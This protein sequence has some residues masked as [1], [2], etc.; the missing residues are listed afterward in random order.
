MVE[1]GK[2]EAILTLDKSKFD[3]GLSQAEGQFTGL[4]SKAA[5]AG[6][7][8]AGAM[9]TAG[10]AA[11]VAV[12][13]IA[14][15]G[16]SA[17]LNVEKAAS[18]AA[19]KA[20]D[21]NG[22]SADQIKAQ[23][24]SIQDHV[25]DISNQLAATTIFDPT[26][27][28]NAFDILAAK[29]ADIANIGQ[30]ELL[31]F[32]DLAAGTQ[33]DLATATDLVTGAINSFGLQMSDSGMVADQMAMAMNGSS[34]A[35][36]TLNYAL[37]QGGATAAA[38]GMQL[39]EF[40]AIVGVLAD[41][42]YTGEQSGA[43][44]KTA[45]LALYTPTQKQTDALA[46]LGLTYD[47]VDPRTHK[48][49]DTLEL[50]LSKGA[51]I[52]DF[53]NIFTDSSGAIMYA[54]AGAGDACDDL[55]A[56]IDG[57]SGLAHAQAS[58]IMDTDK[59]VGA[60]ET[61]KGATEGMTAAI[62]GAL[63]PAA[64]KLL[65]TW[66]AIAPAVQEFAVALASGDWAKAGEM[67]VEAF[68]D[69]WEAIQEIDWGAIATKAVSVIQ[70]GWQGLSNLGSQLLSWLQGVNWSGIAETIVSVVRT[71]WDA[72]QDLGQ[73]LYDWILSVDWAG[74]ATSIATT[75]KDTW[76]TITD[77]AGPIIDKFVEDFTEW[78]DSGGPRTLGE[79]VATAIAKGAADL[80]RWIYDDVKNWWESNGSS[81][82]GAI[83]SVINFAGVAIR[84]A[85]EFVVGFASKVLEL[86]KGTIG[87]S[88]L[89]TIG[90]AMNEAWDGAGDSLIDKAGEWRATIADV[91]ADVPDEIETDIKTTFTGDGNPMTLDG[92]T[93]KVGVVFDWGEDKYKITDLGKDA[94][95]RYRL[96]Q[97]TDTTGGTDTVGYFTSI[98]Q[99]VKSLETAALN[100]DAAA[101]K[102][103][104]AASSNAQSA[105]AN[106]QSSSEVAQATANMAAGAQANAQSTAE[107]GSAAASQALAASSLG[108]QA[109][110]SVDAA[111]NFAA[112]MD[113]QA[114]LSAEAAAASA[115]EFAELTGTASTDAATTTTTASTDAA[116]TTKTAATDS[117][118][119]TKTAAKDSASTWKTGV[120]GT[121]KAILQA[122]QSLSQTLMAA[123]RTIATTLS[124]AA[125]QIR[126]AGNDFSFKAHASA[127]AIQVSG[128]N[129][130]NSVAAGGKAAADALSGAASAIRSAIS[131]VSSL[132]IPAH[133][134]GTRTKGPEIALIGE[135]GSEYVLPADGSRPDLMVQAMGDYG[136]P[137]TALASLSG[138]YSNVSGITVTSAK[139]TGAGQGSALTAALE[140]AAAMLAEA[141]RYLAHT[142]EALGGAVEDMANAAG[143]WASTVRETT[144]E[145]NAINAEAAQINSDLATE[146][147]QIISDMERETGEHNKEVAA[148][149][150]EQVKTSLNGGA[151]ALMDAGIGAGSSITHAGTAFQK[152]I[153]EGGAGFIKICSSAG[154]EFGKKIQ[155]AGQKLTSDIQ[156]GSNLLISA[157]TNAG[158][159]IQRGGQLCGSAVAQGGAYAASALIAAAKAIMSAAAG[160]VGSGEGHAL[161]TV[162]TG[163]ELAW[164]GEAGKEYVIPTTTK[165]WDL[166]YAAMADYGLKVPEMASGGIINTAAI[167]RAGGGRAEGRIVIEDHTV[168]ELYIDGQK[169]T[170]AIMTRS[171]QKIKRR[172]A[173]LSN[174]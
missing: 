124:T 38:S 22:K 89:E 83:A 59:L 49:R 8:I 101:G 50:L 21:V 164:I 55:A 88:I 69:A 133:A 2:A 157:G 87:A 73:T 156:R 106:A 162:T 81:L 128:T 18:S 19:S 141:T 13:G 47:Q 139:N 80:G 158:A 64:V 79:N 167:S 137:D 33:T 82:G 120:D 52:G 125:T 153:G 152:A 40:S 15:A 159:N 94:K 117:A 39:S 41:K 42:N 36:D 155:E 26:Q 105:Q 112:S 9:V 110:A 48:F 77:W 129:C 122:A 138:N 58:L 60:W 12:A 172:Q 121:A 84:A 51:D 147:A 116:T 67:I 75:I 96:D 127:L 109:Q 134:R 66:T 10:V 20:V 61:A 149:I 169:V 130:G 27:V 43:A 150:S 163:P 76:T 154:A 173:A 168:H 174:W 17:F 170:D 7:A 24:D 6:T 72:L 35:S 95:Q 160:M 23:Y 114:A 78:V 25:I 45:M 145:V 151:S 142:A 107:M 63:E 102:E 115:A 123:G 136:I 119:T 99:A 46:K 86:G 1:V 62:G 92:Q 93:V 29:G 57:S 146:T 132:S 3:S 53:G 131:A 32:L 28:A 70:A 144:A 118:T 31:P 91:L 37:R 111:L 140:K 135:A 143:A 30:T 11:G 108:Q 5:G 56:K 85:Y 100:L 16:L 166:L 126:G 34:A 171:M 4:G 98:E 148:E 65:N 68:K 113:Q 97:I 44:L 71:G 161:G 14:T 90:N 103:E 74:L 104:A 165:R 54:L